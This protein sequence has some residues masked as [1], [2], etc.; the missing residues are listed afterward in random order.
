MPTR[1]SARSDLIRDDCSR[2]ARMSAAPVDCGRRGGAQR[3]SVPTTARVWRLRTLGRTA[4]FQRSRPCLYGEVAPGAIVTERSCEQVISTR[5][6]TFVPR[7]GSTL[8]G[9]SRPRSCTSQ[10][11]KALGRRPF[12]GRSAKEGFRTQRTAGADAIALCV[13]D[14][15]QV[16]YELHDPSNALSGM[17]RAVLKFAR[18]A[19]LIEE[20]MQRQRCRQVQC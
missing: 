18:Q 13:E 9:C 17:S 14:R 1:R 2:S 12:L 16:D 20:A 8:S 19:L 7:R 3:A 6:A 10:L 15:V 5:R 11:V 4:A